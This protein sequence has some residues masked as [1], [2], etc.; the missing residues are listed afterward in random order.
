MLD[1]QTPYLIFGRSPDCDVMLDESNVSRRHARVTVDFSGIWIEDLGSKNGIQVGGE[2]VREK[3]RLKDRTEVQ[4]GGVRMMFCDLA[5]AYL[6][7]LD[8]SSR[9]VSAA[10]SAADEEEAEAPSDRSVAV[11]LATG[12]DSSVSL[13]AVAEE[14]GSASKTML[15]LDEAGN[16]S[17]S[18]PKLD[19]LDA[20]EPELTH[21]ASAPK[22][23]Q[24]LLLLGLFEAL[25]C[26]CWW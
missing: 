18:M 17:K 23:D 25:R 4:V 2:V 5:S 21:D 16:W 24:D 12:Q 19:S 9:E 13:D 6:G 1:G 11:P 7:D 26:C 10:Q 15:E 3:V 22:F 20:A 14:D 8:K